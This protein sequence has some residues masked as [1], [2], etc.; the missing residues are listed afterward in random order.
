MKL[1]A[2]DVEVP[3]VSSVE[4]EFNKSMVK[5]IDESVKLISSAEAMLGIENYSEALKYAKKA[6]KYDDTRLKAA[7]IVANAYSLQGEYSKALDFLFDLLK[8]GELSELEEA[9]I[10]E[11]IGEIYERLGEK[12]KAYHWYVEAN[13]VLN[14]KDLSVKIEKL[15]R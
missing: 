1:K 7:T 2:K 4:P 11:E 5:N 8:K 13:K 14:D 15:K 9:K 3:A 10:K 12:E 6:L